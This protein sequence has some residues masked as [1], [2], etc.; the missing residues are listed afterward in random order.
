MKIDPLLKVLDSDTYLGFDF[1]L[2]KIGVAVGQ[3]E[4]GI[5]NPL[6]TVRSL[7]QKPNWRTLSELVEQWKPRGFVVGLSLQADGTENPVSQTMHKFCRQLEGR[8]RLPVFRFDEFLT[9]VEAKRSL[10]EEH[11]LSASKLWQV[12]DQVAAQ[13][14]L[15]SW[16]NHNHT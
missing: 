3:L 16:L 7:N 13:L 12:Q 1:G 4:T 5:A 8:Y 6:K 14:I 10:F 2:R 15:Q 11:E 9:T